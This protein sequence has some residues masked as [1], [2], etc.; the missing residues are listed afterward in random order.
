MS[1][2]ASPCR[3]AGKLIAVIQPGE[4]H[5]LQCWLSVHVAACRWSALQIPPLVLPVLLSSVCGPYGE[6]IWHLGSGLRLTPAGCW[7][8]PWGPLGQALLLGAC[9][10][11]TAPVRLPL[12]GP[13]RGA[14][15]GQS[16]PQLCPRPG[17]SLERE[18]TARNPFSAFPPWLSPH[19]AWQGGRHPAFLL[20][21]SRVPSHT[22]SFFC[23]SLSWAKR[24]DRKR[25]G[26][27][28]LLTYNECK[29]A[30]RSK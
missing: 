9:G 22:L 20:R 4:P 1:T 14:G 6:G 17:L 5:P 25:D 27:R 19:S 2:P 16:C 15:K 18:A 12:P 26:E 7:L 21:A 29:S 28:K 24:V 13:Q 8:L 10:A 30:V 23:S 11:G 3:T